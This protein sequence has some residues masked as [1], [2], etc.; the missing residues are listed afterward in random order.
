MFSEIKKKDS[1]HIILLDNLVWLVVAFKIV[2]TSKSSLC[3]S[4]ECVGERRRGRAVHCHS[5][6]CCLALRVCV[7][8]AASLKGVPQSSFD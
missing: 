4:W 7:V 8:D 3:L 6:D 1:Q 2:V 5:T